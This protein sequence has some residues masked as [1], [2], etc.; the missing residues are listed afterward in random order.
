[1][2]PNNKDYRIYYI[3]DPCIKGNYHLIAQLQ[4]SVTESNPGRDQG[5][6]ISLLIALVSLVEFVYQNSSPVRQM[7]L[8]KFRLL[9]TQIEK[10][11]VN[12]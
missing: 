4:G 9:G 8:V 6:N 5:S 10:R 3:L 1:M 2:G 7:L 11:V 12:S